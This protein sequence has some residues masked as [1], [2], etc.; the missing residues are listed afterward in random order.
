MKNGSEDKFP[1]DLTIAAESMDRLVLRIADVERS[2]SFGV[3]LYTGH[4]T[5]RDVA[6]TRDV[7]GFVLAL[8]FANV[9]D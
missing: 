6:G 8:I 3:L 2:I 4:S 9:M 7:R 1:G 5:V